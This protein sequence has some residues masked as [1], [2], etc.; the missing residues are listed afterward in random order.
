M[1]W[2]SILHPW[3]LPCEFES[4]PLSCYDFNGFVSIR[5]PFTH[6]H[7]HTRFMMWLSQVY[8]LHVALIHFHSIFLICSWPTVQFAT[9][10]H[11]GFYFTMC[12]I[13]WLL[14]FN[15]FLTVIWSFPVD[16]KKTP[17]LS[18]IFHTYTDQNSV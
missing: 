12:N 16:S 18:D 17:Q 14:N 11:I 10:L 13:Q 8:N 9:C 15:I 4:F 3:F 2:Y 7:Q 5:F 1:I 6:K